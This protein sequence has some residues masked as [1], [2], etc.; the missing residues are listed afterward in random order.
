MK[1]I[2]LIGF[3]GVGKTTIGRK[4]GKELALSVV[5]TD[6]EMVNQQGVEIP[7]I[8]SKH[9][10]TYFREL[11]EKI[12][13]Q[14]GSKENVIVTTGGGMVLSSQNRKWMHDNGVVVWLDCQFETIWQRV[15]GDHNRPL[16]NGAS[17]R[18]LFDRYTSRYALY[19]E[20]AHFKVNTEDDD[21]VNTIHHI[22]KGLKLN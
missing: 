16:S 22:L 10:E 5:D 8:F 11:E 3:M 17:Y 12:L 19:E 15:S 21:V 20:A 2:F 6:E 7:I 1:P 4:L 14:C 13:V 18:E 9:G